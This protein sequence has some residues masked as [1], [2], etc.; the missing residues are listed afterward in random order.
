MCVPNQD[1]ALC[2][3]IAATNIYSL[4]GYNKWNCTSQGLTSTNPCANPVWPGII[5]GISGITNNSVI[6]IILGSLGL[7]GNE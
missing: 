3:L 1:N 7:T 2:G 4:A 6:S 5:C